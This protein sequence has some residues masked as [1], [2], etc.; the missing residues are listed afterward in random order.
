MIVLI[1]GA[2]HTG[3]TFLA[4][5]LLEKYH[6]PYLSMD[7]V[8]MGL[9]RAKYTNIRVEEDGLLTEYLW[10][11]IR[12]MIK[13]AIENHQ[14][15][16]VEGCYIPFDWRN[17]LEQQYLSEIRFICLAMT[18]EYIHKNFDKIINQESIIETRLFS[19]DLN[20]VYLIKENKMFIDGFTL[21]K[22]YIEII[23]DDYESSIAKILDYSF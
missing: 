10:P 16:V 4:Q 6:Y 2:S 3:K 8:K 17:D 5:K 20:E 19:A 22:E 21:R 18:E 9:I 12:E 7:H 11:V 15:L 1:T 14:N 13:T 23:D